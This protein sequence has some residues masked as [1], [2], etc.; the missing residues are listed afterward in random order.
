METKKRIFEVHI[1]LENWEGFLH[2]SLTA[3]LQLFQQSGESQEVNF[4]VLLSLSLISLTHF[5]LVPSASLEIVVLFTYIWYI[6]HP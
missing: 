5:H 2:P 3:M 4:S 1:L 6:S